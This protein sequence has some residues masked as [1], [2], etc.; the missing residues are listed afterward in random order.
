MQQ[1]QNWLTND[2]FDGVQGLSERVAAR[3]AGTT[4]NK[5]TA[6]KILLTIPMTFLFIERFIF[7]GCMLYAIACLL[8]WVDGALARYH[9]DRGFITPPEQEAT[10]S[11]WARLDIR[12]KSELGK[13]LDPFADKL[14]FF[15][16]LIPLGA[17][18]VAWPLIATSAVF[19]IALTLFRVFKK[20]LGFIGDGAANRFGKWKM[21]CEIL[22]IS[23]IVLLPHDAFGKII[24]TL[25]LICAVILAFLSFAVQ[26]YTTPR[27]TSRDF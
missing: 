18:Y 9:R 4:S 7:L 13:S 8:D 22:V 19:A 11:F 16:A 1:N 20:E 3:F 21:W 10:M 27:S 6:F 24:S 15:G 14:T 17:G 23:A 5:I 12:G 25:L 26:W 2:R